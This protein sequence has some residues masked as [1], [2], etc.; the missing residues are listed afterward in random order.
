V[1]KSKQ[2]IFEILYFS[3]NLSE[4][5]NGLIVGDVR[6]N[7]GVQLSQMYD[8]G[9]DGVLGVPNT[10]IRIGEGYSAHSGITL[11]SAVQK[12]KNLGRSFTLPTQEE[13]LKEVQNKFIYDN[14]QIEGKELIVIDEAIF[15]GTTAKV[16]L[17]ELRDRGAKKLHFLASVPLVNMGCAN[18]KIS[19][20][21]SFFLFSHLADDYAKE[22]GADTYNHLPLDVALEV[23][24]KGG[25]GCGKCMQGELIKVTK[26]NYYD[27]GSGYY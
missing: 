7:V 6:F 8:V 5:I 11:S 10:A 23:Y 3:E 13:R 15:R 19:V 26:D 18:N 20:L 25:N 14:N 17:K 22:I 4:E 2:C 16:V 21:D 1:K 27:Y 9:G 24:S 12:K